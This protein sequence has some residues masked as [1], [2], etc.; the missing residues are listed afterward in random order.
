MTPRGCEIECHIAINSYKL[1]LT[2]QRR[3][4]LYA[5]HWFMY[6]RRLTKNKKK[7]NDNKISSE[8]YKIS[9]STDQNSH[10]ELDWTECGLILGMSKPIVAHP[11]SF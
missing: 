5:R 8:R 3:I 6:G 7:N 9:Y 11:H 10:T 1:P 2:F 4:G